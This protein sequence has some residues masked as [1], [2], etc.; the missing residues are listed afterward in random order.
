MAADGDCS[1]GI[2]R[3]LLFGGKA[4]TNLDS[5]LKSRDINKGLSIQG[6]GF[7]SGH[8][9]LWELDY[10]ESWEQKNW[11]FWTAVL[12][13]TLRVSWTA[14][15]STQSILKEV[16]P[17]CSLEGLMLKLKLQYFGHLMWGAD[18]F[19]KTVMLGKIEG[20]RRSNR[21][22]GGSMASPTQWTWVWANAGGWWWTGRPGMQ[23]F[24]ELQSRTRLSD[25]TELNCSPLETF[26]PVI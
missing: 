21:G 15:R 17:G 9:W 18:S 24:M 7:S 11:C 8:V 5:I 4:M 3:R 1:H 26:Y 13:K 2:K 16:S 12:E 6:Y 10:K 20:R 14:R 23:W 22:W 25:W 19:E